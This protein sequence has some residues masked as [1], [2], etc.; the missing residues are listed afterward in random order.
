MTTHFHPVDAAA[1]LAAM[2]E[3]EARCDRIMLLLGDKRRLDPDELA[4]VREQYTS[5]KT[6][7][8]EAAKAPYVHEPKRARELSVCESAF[9]DPAVRKAHIALRPATNSNPISSRWFSAVHEAQ[10]EFSYYRHNLTGALEKAPK[11]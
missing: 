4:D 10:M 9:Y 8:K 5:L 3:F 6:D 11:A 2:E 1:V 7:L